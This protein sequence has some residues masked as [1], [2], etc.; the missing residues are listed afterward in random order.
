MCGI[1]NIVKIILNALCHYK[2][3]SQHCQVIM[4]QICFGPIRLYTYIH[5]HTSIYIHVIS[6]TQHTTQLENI[7]I[8]FSYTVIHPK[9]TSNKAVMDGEETWMIQIFMEHGFQHK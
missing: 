3:T 7:V 1:V 9:D 2:I 8:Q 4:H 6:Y 5:I